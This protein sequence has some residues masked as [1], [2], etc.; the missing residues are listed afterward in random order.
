MNVNYI[1]LYLLFFKEREIRN[2]MLCIISGKSISEIIQE[3]VNFEEDSINFY[4]FQCYEK[5]D[6]K[7]KEELKIYAKKRIL[8]LK[9]EEYNRMLVK[10]RNLS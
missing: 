3:N 9:K 2:V 1:H 8:N 10:A 5:L 6:M 4:T 7:E